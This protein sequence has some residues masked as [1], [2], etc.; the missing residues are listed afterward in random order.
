M[1]TVQDF[2]S[3][4]PQFAG[5]SPLVIQS[6]LDQ[7]IPEYRS[8]LEGWLPITLNLTAHILMMRAKGISD[9][10]AMM[11]NANGQGSPQTRSQT[12]S[13]LDPLDGSAYGLEVKRLLT[14]VSSGFMFF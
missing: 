7:A 2:L 6:A 11:A 9:S 14:P 8:D 13:K 3:H 4:F 10:V 5:V 12:G 1:I